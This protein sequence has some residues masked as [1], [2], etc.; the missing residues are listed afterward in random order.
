MKTQSF[1]SLDH[2]IQLAMNQIDHVVNHPH[3]QP[4]FESSRVDD[5]Y[6]SFVANK[7]NLLVNQSS[8]FDVNDLL[9]ALAVQFIKEGSVGIVFGESCDLNQHTLALLSHQSGIDVNAIK[10]GQLSAD[11]W[12]QLNQA[13]AQCGAWP[14]SLFDGL[15]E[16]EFVLPTLPASLTC[17]TQTLII[18]MPS[19]EPTQ[20]M[21]HPLY[22]PLM[23]LAQ[24]GQRI[25]LV[26][27]NP[28]DDEQVFSL[29]KM[30]QD[31][32]LI[33]L[34]TAHTQ[35]SSARVSLCFHRNN[36]ASLNCA[37]YR[38]T[39]DPACSRLTDSTEHP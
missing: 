21:R 19:L 34:K 22:A 1:N 31:H 13:I 23:D 20:W 3:S 8:E 18:A 32:S 33:Q 30:Q 4:Y 7:L 35:A 25:I 14:I 17:S 10:L 29:F 5:F 16:N 27:Q 12:T 15:I 39:Y 2:Y 28:L 9:T 6:L 38:L 36:Q 37:R 11:Q 26:L 24:T